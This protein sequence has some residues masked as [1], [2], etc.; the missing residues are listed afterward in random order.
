MHKYR[1]GYANSSG[2]VFNAS[3]KKNCKRKEKI[4]SEKQ[5]K[6]MLN[7]EGEK[8]QTRVE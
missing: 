6:D 5:C 7:L 3:P 1:C 4:K 2:M 8:D